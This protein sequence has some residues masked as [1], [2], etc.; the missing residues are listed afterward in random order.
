MLVLYSFGAKLRRG[1]EEYEHERETFSP[2]RA[3]VDFLPLCNRRGRHCPTQ[4][5]GTARVMILPGNFDIVQLSPSQLQHAR[6]KLLFSP[7]VR[8]DIDY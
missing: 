1:R 7:V 8:F 4:I 2:F 5:I 6:V 3:S